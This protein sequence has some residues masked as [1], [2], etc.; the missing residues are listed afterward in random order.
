MLN[1]CLHL[2][3][4]GFER[5]KTLSGP[6]RSY[7]QRA[8]ESGGFYFEG[9]AHK[10][11]TVGAEEKEKAAKGKVEESSNKKQQSISPLQTCKEM[12]IGFLEMIYGH[13]GKIAGRLGINPG[14][15][16]VITGRL[17]MIPGL[18]GK[19]SGPCETIPGRLGKKAGSLVIVPGHVGGVAGLLEMFIRSFF[20]AGV[21]IN[22]KKNKLVNH[23]ISIN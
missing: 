8:S 12:K 21:T 2:T 14:Q 4:T 22:Y 1:N 15:L 18:L 17:E 9:K 13:L 19:V 7:L 6:L 10:V 20:V 3:K 16:R 5:P 11:K 23:S